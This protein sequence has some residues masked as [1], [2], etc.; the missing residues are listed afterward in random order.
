MKISNLKVNNHIILNRQSTLNTSL[1]LNQSAKMT[2]KWKLDQVPLI[3]HNRE[4]YIYP[5]TL[6][7]IY[8]DTDVD[9]DL[10]RDMMINSNG[11]VLMKGNFLCLKM[12]NHPIIE[13]VSSF[14]PFGKE[15]K[16]LTLSCDNSQTSQ[17]LLLRAK[18]DID[19][20]SDDSQD[21]GGGK[22]YKVS[23]GG[24]TGIV[25]VCVVVCVAIASF[26]VYVIQKKKID[27]LKNE[28]PR[29]TVEV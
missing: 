25:I 6:E 12:R 11:L 14:K 9:R 24:I 1:I 10:F 28:I 22:D 20:D 15:N 18:K 21:G 29:G 8:E 23:V 7:L 4:P 26:I 13:F 3:I 5:K 17:I 27:E 19:D 16:Y 2:I